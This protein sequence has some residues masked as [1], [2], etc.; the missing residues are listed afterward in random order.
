MQAV[1]DNSDWFLYCPKTLRDYELDPRNLHSEFSRQAIALEVPHKKVPARKIW[2]KIQELQ[3]T[4]GRPYLAFQDAINNGSP[5][6]KN[7]GNIQSVNLCVAPETLL[8]TTAGHNEIKSYDGQTIN[9][10][11]G[12]EWSLS[13]VFKT[14]ENQ[15]L[16]SVSFTDGSRVDAT[17]DHNWWIKAST[18]GNEHCGKVKTKDLLTGMIVP[19]INYP[20]IAGYKPFDLAY[21][22]GRAMG[23][24]PGCEYFLE[25]RLEWLAGLFDA[26]GCVNKQENGVGALQVSVHTH[27]FVN[28]LRLMLQTMGIR[29]TTSAGGLRLCIA[30]AQAYKLHLLGF[31]LRVL[32]L[33]FKTKPKAGKVN[34]VRVLSVE[35]HGRVSDTYCLT[36]PLKNT[37]VFNGVVSS[38][39][40]E[41]YSFFKADEYIHTCSLGSINLGAHASLADVVSTAKLMSSIVDCS[42][43]LS[44]IDIPEVKRH[45]KDFR[46]L[47]IGLMG[48]ADWLAMQ[49]TSYGDTKAISDVAEAVAYGVYKQSLLN[50]AA[51]GPC[52]ANDYLEPSALMLSLEEKHPGLKNLREDYGIRN[53]LML[54]TAP[55]TSTSITMG[56]CPSFLPPYNLQGW[57][58]KN[59]DR[60]SQV[61]LRYDPQAYVMDIKDTPP[62]YCLDAALAVQKWTDAGVSAEFLL[63]K[64]KAT[65][66]N[67]AFSRLKLRAWVENLKA[68]YY[69]RES[70]SEKPACESCAQ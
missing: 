19:K 20:V 65:S 4:I 38:Q 50:A 49:G 34:Y 7:F 17:A 52:G 1:E 51:A 13:K 62:E 41:S 55:N 56:A 61:V 45:I 69:I 67:A 39:C 25:D 46:T 27:L 36:E 5:F 32:D 59:G 2:A 10:W 70:E 54:C 42:L 11:N 53:A 66:S 14:G 44:L 63:S 29:A 28:N 9:V 3:R 16:Y 68:V 57:V 26:N 35:D 30:S 15:K 6:K 31:K 22:K 12:S 8:L 24:V 18:R 33:D 60:S 21:E 37:V 48:L 23:F 58:E 47:G 64:G 40:V 43:E